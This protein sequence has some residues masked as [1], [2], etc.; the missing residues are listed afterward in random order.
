VKQSIDPGQHLWWLAS[1]SFGVVAIVLVSLSVGLGL[2]LSGRLLRGPGMAARIKT[3]HE[4][5]AV[6]GLIAIVL[7]GLLLLG[8]SFLHPGLTGIAL[9]FVI[10]TQRVWTAMGV[11]GGWLAAVVTLSFYVRHLI[12]IAVWRWLH[13]WTLGVYALGIAHTLGSGTDARATWL[14]A[15][16]GV[17]ALPIVVAGLN[18]VRDSSRQRAARR[19]HPSPAPSPS[20]QVAYVNPAYQRPNTNPNAP[21]DGISSRR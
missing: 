6:S 15:I 5:F 9:P 13:R 14:L 1:R 7:H 3:L 11:I 19:P 10:G 21:R 8:D 4:A 12:G 20:S 2:S 17:T 18:R 16:L